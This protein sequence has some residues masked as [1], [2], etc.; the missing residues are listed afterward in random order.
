MD[1]N[2][3]Y[4]FSPSTLDFS[5][6]PAVL[7]AAGD[8][9]WQQL[10]YAHKEFE[11]FSDQEKNTLKWQCALSDFI[12]EAV[13]KQPQ[14]FGQVLNQTTQPR[15]FFAQQSETFQQQA[16]AITDEIKLGKLLRQYRLQQMA[17]IA[18][19]D[20]NGSIDLDQAFEFISQLADELI[21]T[22]TERLYQILTSTLGTPTNDQGETQ[23]FFVL[24]MGKL[25]GS[26]LNFSSDIDLIFCYPDAGETQGASRSLS[27]HEFFTR[28]GQRL[29]NALNQQTADGFVYR[30]DMRLRPYGDSGPLVMNYNMLEDYYEE[31]G[32]DWER[33]AMLKARI[34]TPKQ[35]QTHPDYAYLENLI[36]PFVYRRY[37]DFSAIESL[38]KMKQ[39]IVQENRR[40]GLV[41]NIKLGEGGIREVEFI[42]QA[43]QLIRGGREV[44][45]RTR[46]TRT[47]LEKLNLL[48]EMS[49]ED[50]QVLTQAYYFLRKTEHVLQQIADKQTQTLPDN[51]IDQARLYVAMGFT[52]WQEFKQILDQ[53]TQAVNQVF[54]EVIKSD[55]EDEQADIEFDYWLCNLDTDAAISQLEHD[56]HE[57]DA[58]AFWQQV[59]Q[60]HE[61]IKKRAVG[62]RG[63]E[64]IDKLMPRL[65]VAC[66]QYPSAHILISR[67]RELV[68]SICTRTAYLEL[69]FENPQT[70]TILLDCLQASPWIAQ[71]LSQQA[72]LLDELLDPR[73]LYKEL[74]PSKYQADLRERLLRID[75]EDLEAIMD[76]LRQFKHAYQLRI[77]VADILGHLP[78]MKVSDHLTWLAEAIL[79]QVVNIAWQHTTEKH[80]IPEGLVGTSDKGFAVLG[81]GK[82]G[83]LE[84]GYGSDLDMVFVHN[85]QSDQQ[86]TGERAV[87]ITQFY[88]RLAQRIMHIYSAQTH[89]GILYEIDMRLRPS[90]N[91]GLLVATLKGFENYQQQDAW[92]WEHQALVR[93]RC[94]Y[95]DK[96][97]VEQLEQVRVQ[98]LS[99]PRDISALNKDVTDMRLK[100][101]KHLAKG[102]QQEF[103]VKQ[104]R[105]GIAD[106]EFITQ[107]LVLANAHK[108]PE[109]CK[110]SDN[111]RI[112]T[113]AAEV[114]V[115]EPQQAEQLIDAYKLFR[116]ES[117]K[118]ALAQTK[119]ISRLDPFK[120][121]IESV[122]AIW[123]SIFDPI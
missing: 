109:L 63:A 31:Q 41:N 118:L 110:Y 72:F 47:A 86:T 85:Q 99:Q 56:Y 101:F 121:A 13:T 20:F 54:K 46:S 90:G 25:G 37:I 60:C 66:L 12:R 95:G 5:T 40:R 44:E 100:M 81:Y 71:Q 111:I 64:I 24:G 87:G 78:L 107:Y 108:Y 116:N 98:I 22:A 52:S 91:S 120:H 23:P 62:K 33:Y 119:V 74:D 50:I 16:N 7:Q 57:V 49:E 8:K 73:Q 17:W 9:A 103:D 19:M 30:V 11:Q 79:S 106:I 122:K 51:E 3:P 80:G 82:L 1:S 68:V 88:I 117:H 18:W 96:D 53:H 115:I 97:L 32:R 14:F 28:L 21:Q 36:R 113:T 4:Q 2:R 61:Q 77:A 83:G 112:L 70:R 29:I 35:W 84:F 48:G 45:L 58:A 93:A 69:L 38:R 94:V 42:V 6:L 39:L 123:Q 10:T 26:E 67:I 102:N 59:S 34:I 75:P 15:E 76:T 43:F 92:T 27:N 89:A 114:G 105:G 104:D 65:I 55:A